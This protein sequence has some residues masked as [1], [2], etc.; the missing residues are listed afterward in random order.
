M[1]NTVVLL[2]ALLLAGIPCAAP[3]ASPAAS[4]P[5][6]TAVLLTPTVPAGFSVPA[7]SSPPSPTPAMEETDARLANAANARAVLTMLKLTLSGNQKRFLDENKFLLVPKRATA[8]AGKYDLASSTT[9]EGY[10]EMLGMF[11]Q[12]GGGA[13]P[14]DR[15]PE[16][17]RFV[18]S[19]IVLHAMGKYFENALE[20]LEDTELVPMLAGFVA[21]LRNQALA[22]KTNTAGELADRLDT[23]AAQLT[24]PLV[25]L[26]NAAAA[27][28]K[29]SGEPARSKN[30]PDAVDTEKAALA[31]LNAYKKD[32]TP[33]A[34]ARAA[35]ELKLVYAAKTVAV[36]PLFGGYDPQAGL[37]TDYTQYQP[38]GH[39]AK[40]S[41]LRGYFRAMI[42]LGRN[43]WPLTTPTGLSDAL[44]VMLLTAEPGRT[45]P[46]PLSQWQRIMDVTGFFAGIPDDIA[47]PGLRDFT[48]RVL[49]QDSLSPAEAVAPEVRKKLAT[50]LDE[51]PLPRVLADILDA[52][53]IPEATKQE[54]LARTRTFRLFGQRFS[55]DA[56]IF[57]RLTAGQEKSDLRLPS[58]P[59]ALFVPAAL[60]NRTARDLSAVFLAGG[61]G[62]SPAE[63]E[64]FLGRLDATAGEL[65][66]MPETDH[67][68]SLASGW[69]HVLSTLGSDYGKGWPGFMQSKP[70]AVKQ[71]ETVL[72]SYAELKHANL[73]YAKQ[74]YA[75]FGGGGDD[76]TPPPVPKGFVEPNP[77]FW[78]AL[79]RLVDTAAAGFAHYKLLPVE[80][81]ESGRL[82]QFRR[83]I[84]LFA[85]LADKEL[86]NA[87]IDE[88]DY[89]K[90]RLAN[91]S[92][93]ASPF[94]DV[95]LEPD[96]C[97]SALTADVH[98]DAVSGA[99]LYEATAEPYVM[100]ALVG[101]ESSPRL[102][103]GTAFNHYEFARPLAEGRLTDQAWR[104]GVYASPP[105]L[106][107]KNAWYKELLVK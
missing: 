46:T 81:E 66:R 36:S 9:P 51:L 52:P 90:L 83:D 29:T 91:L 15:L 35:E 31:R 89:E 32:M 49:G 98:T 1:S 37:K 104:A 21:T 57:S 38:R 5:G 67:Y 33:Q 92:Y 18:T 4:P 72:G 82:G 11:D 6:G 12:V 76:G 84:A 28:P 59:T 19:D 3:A 75:E 16:N 56:W 53:G 2:V 80:L 10:D 68:A 99:V 69:L 103:V 95:I 47:Y 101:N 97:K 14:L 25:L 50:R 63:V 86:R 24:V 55:P 77:A 41:R 42:Y 65:A 20:H 39:Y 30:V 61:Q 45:A 105:K 7:T 26:E 60:G 106:P 64:A 62:F 102:V 79:A 23:V 40:N 8:Y 107:A 22:H 88:D 93:M 17:V 74:N 54:L 85:D 96:Q 94:G 78:A 48:A 34:L 70:F 43:G 27:K 100:L 71:I 58:M 13:D 44:L 87:P 73:L